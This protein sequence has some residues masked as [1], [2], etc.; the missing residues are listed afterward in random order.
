MSNLFQLY[1]IN[2]RKHG[3]MHPCKA[4][5]KVQ[6]DSLNGGLAHEEDKHWTKDAGW[7]VTLGPDHWRYKS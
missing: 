2:T 1:N 7:R 6:R 3:D 5:A 4:N